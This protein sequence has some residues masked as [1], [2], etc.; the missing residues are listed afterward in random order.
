MLYKEYI[1]VEEDFIPVFSFASDKSHPERWKSFYP[2]ESF[3]NIF[4]LTVETLEKASAAKDR[5]IWINGSYGTGKTFASFVIKHIFED[6]FSEVEKYFR[7]HEMDSL[8]PRV[9]ALRDKGKILVVHQSSSSGIN[10]QNKLFNAIIEAVK[11]SLR[12]NGYTYTGAAS[13][14]GKVLA[15]LKDPDATFNFEAAFKKYRAK[16]LDYSSPKEVIEDLETLDAQEQLDLLEVIA[17]VAESESYNWS[18]SVNDVIDWLRDVRTKNNLYAIFFIWDEFTEYFRN[19]FNNVTGLQELAQ[20]AP[21]L[22]FYFFL[23]THGSSNQL[24]TDDTLRKIIAARF[25]IASI[26]LEKNTAFE[27]MA[28]AFEIVP[29]QKSEWQKISSVLW[30]KVKRDAADFIATRD[31]NVKVDDLKNLLPIHPFAAYLLKFIAQAVSSNQRTMFQF[32]S[33]EADNNFYNFIQN[34]GDDDGEIF[35]TADY[36]WDYFFHRDNSDLDEI[37]REV[38]GHYNT[39]STFCND[40]QCR[41]LKVLLILFALQ[42]K[43][44]QS[45]EGSSVL[46][47]PS[48]KNISACFAGTS[49]EK[50]ISQILDFFVERGII[51]A[52]EESADVYYIMATTQIDPARMKK[53]FDEVSARK[54][55]DNIIRDDSYGVAKFFR[56]TDFLKYRLDIQ[57][58]SPTK[59][60]QLPHIVAAPVNQIPTFFIFAADE[61]EQGKVKQTIEKIFAKSSQRTII[62]DFSATPFTAQRYEKFLQNKARELYFKDSQNQAGQVKLAQKNA[63]DLVAEWIR[64]LTV[65]SVRVL[66]SPKDSVS[67]SGEGNFHKYL[68]ELNGKFFGGGIEE[69]SLNEKLFSTTGLTENVARAALD[70][71][72]IRGNISWLNFLS[73]PFRQL[74]KSAGEKYW[75]A[76]PSDPI[77]K[78]KAI[79][80]DLIAARFA[81]NNEISFGE[82]WDELRKSPVG[83]MK[84]PGSIFLLALML[85]DYAD[86]NFYLRDYNSNTS[87][88]TGER[89]CSLIVAVVKDLPQARDNFIVKQTAEHLKFCKLIAEIFNLRK[90]DINSIDDASKFI[91]ALLAQSR[92]PLWML[93]YLLDEKFSTGYKAELVDALNLFCE[94]INPPPGRDIT[95]IADEIFDICDTATAIVDD[96]KKLLRPKNF[97]TGMEFHLKKNHPD[98]KKIL[99]RLKISDDEA[100]SLLNGKISSSTAYLLNLAEIDRRIENLFAELQLVESVNLILDS[101]QKNL[102]DVRFALKKKLNQIKVPRVV[103][104]EFFPEFKDLFQAFDSLLSHTATDFTLAAEIVKRNARPFKKFFDNQFDTFAKAVTGLVDGVPDSQILESVFKDMPDGIFFMTRED[105]ASQLKTLLKKINRIKKTNLLF[106]IWRDITGTPSPAEWS[107]RNEIPILCVF[108]KNLDIAQNCFAA[109]NSQTTLANDSD[110]NAALKFIQSDEITAL[111]KKDK[112]REDFRSYFCGDLRLIVDD[113]SLRAILRK[114]AGNDVYSWF[115][116]KKICEGHIRAFANKNYNKKF[117]PTVRKIIRDMN[118]QEAKKYLDDLTHDMLFGVRILENSGGGG[119]DGL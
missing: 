78:M 30:E 119:N 103:T 40:S 117:L 114:H 104:E 47:R 54:S 29:A 35:L 41:A 84:C 12:S 115:T 7:H 23:I 99:R 10:S 15:T 91:K 37:F 108:Q 66:T 110:L 53:I 27:L 42:Q 70:N 64:Q 97:K 63:A 16:F 39:Y 81:H 58:I 95:K 49:I 112:C 2:H 22:N 51:S 5:P 113:D 73:E 57:I 36:L 85:K 88:L 79:V 90:D 111:A 32:I 26:D 34:H 105:F 46:L 67:I 74:V 56:P 19:N 87:S 52:L 11:I 62:A 102:A 33:E 77:S 75:L 4:T 72:R 106:S 86:N 6:D 68:R 76:D 83:L 31:P 24:I 17:D 80:E 101:P 1:K 107:K 50:D 59:F 60:L 14:L 3:R 13:I 118:A 93:T 55:F 98:F 8:I 61:L 96:L 20:R 18:M 109:L 69:I 89:L 48:K 94:F 25:K 43:V 21:E 82:I 92:Y 116:K 100:F 9:A 44:F 71:D 45:Q 65:S 38:M 28:Q